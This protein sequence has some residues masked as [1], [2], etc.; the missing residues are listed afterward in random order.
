MPSIE[1]P[2]PDGTGT[3]H[4]LR[5]GPDP[6]GSAGVILA[7]HG[8]TASA[9]SWATLA[10]TLP[11]DWS[12]V[13][14]DLR[15][16]GR[17]ST[18]SGP[19]GIDQHARDLAALAAAIGRDVVLT[20]HSL[21]GY[22]A[23]RAA[24]R[25][26]VR[27]TRLVLVD[28]GLPLQAPAGADPDAVLEATVGPAIA[29]LRMRFES[30]ADY[31]GFFQRHPALAKSW[32]EDVADYVRYDLTGEP[33]DLRSRVNAEAVSAD[34]R[35]LVLNAASFGEDLAGL[36][37]PAQLLYAPQGMLGEPPGLLTQPVVSQWTRDSRLTAELV[38]DCNHYTILF[39]PRA[40]E[41]VGA[42]LVR[43]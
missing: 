5:F 24:A 22:A 28:G 16:R 18:V 40:A 17:S 39:D 8:I 25:F 11:G 31:L 14:L 30:E 34:G 37:L 29:R 19:F 6:A 7:A 23:L 2:A 36:D 38:P 26:R 12:L 15:G 27:F 20:G 4:A 33:G 43:P 3:L 10:G 13:A 35:D 1:I 41:Q 21:G 42:E 9:M 32:T